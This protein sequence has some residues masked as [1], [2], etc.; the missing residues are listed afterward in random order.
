MDT[1][2]T[3]ENHLFKHQPHQKHEQPKEP[4][5]KNPKNMLSRWA[6][7]KQLL[8]IL[9]MEDREINIVDV[10]QLLTNGADVNLIDDDNCYTPLHLAVWRDNKKTVSLL[11][12]HGAPINCRSSDP[13]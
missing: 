7:G 6:L 13:T 3:K 11:I 4:D 8:N 9:S 2:P 5:L 10:Q 12:E 1:S